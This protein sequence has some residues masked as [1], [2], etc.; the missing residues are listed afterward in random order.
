MSSIRARA[1]SAHVEDFV[2]P[3]E[4]SLE[5]VIKEEG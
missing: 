5:S 3:F 2:A 1:G 4:R